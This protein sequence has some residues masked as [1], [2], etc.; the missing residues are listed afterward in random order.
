MLTVGSLFSGIGGLD[1]GLERAGM[2]VIWQVENDPYCN[3][4]LAKHWPEVKRYGDIKDI[5][6]SEVER[7]D[8]VCGGFPC[9]PVSVAGKRLGTEDERWLW[10]EFRRCLRGVGPRFVFVENVPGLLAGGM[11]DVLGDLAGLGYDA[12]W[13]SLPAS[14]FGAPHL[15]YRVFIVAHIREHRLERGEQAGPAA[16]AA[17]RGGE[18]ADANGRGRNRVRE[19]EQPTLQGPCGSEPHGRSSDRGFFNTAPRGVWKP[20]PDV[21]RVADGVP[22][23][24]DITGVVQ[25][26]RK[27]GSEKEVEMATASAE[28]GAV[29]RVRILRLYL[30]LTT[31][32]PELEYAIGGDSSMSEMSHSDREGPQQV[33][34]WPEKEATVCD[35]RKL[36]SAK[37]L[38]KAQNMQPEM[39]L[40]P[41]EVQRWLAVGSRVH[42]LRALGNAVVPAVS[43]FIGRIIMEHEQA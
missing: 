22:S 27:H 13:E 39:P 25:Y 21:G 33:G 37:P 36:V 2:E 6:W 4:V 20:E 30:G 10:P 43:E 24:L 19:P 42:R 15:R 14:A 29:G 11:G 31:S 28:S 26:I 18:V 23:A 7:P 17:R 9:Q 3:K 38:R 35:L 41:R 5:D 1:L 8:L 40:D 12:E 16:G 32:P 34:P